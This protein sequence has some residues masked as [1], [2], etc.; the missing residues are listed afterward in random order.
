MVASEVELK[1]DN[2]CTNE[3]VLKANRT[4]IDAAL[5]HAELQRGYFEHDAPGLCADFV[6]LADE[7]LRLRK[8]VEAAVAWRNCSEADSARLL[9]QLTLDVDALEESMQNSPS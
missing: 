9:A 6:L 8:V 7:V 3:G 1:M 2:P 4:P 5:W